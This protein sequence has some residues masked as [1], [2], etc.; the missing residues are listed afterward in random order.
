MLTHSRVSQTL[1][2]GEGGLVVGNTSGRLPLFAK[3]YGGG[4]HMVRHHPMHVQ[5]QRV[6]YAG[7]WQIRHSN[8]LR[9]GLVRIGY[10]Y[11]QNF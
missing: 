10:S 4:D 1:I 7:G 11:L 5:L 8:L 2:G 3:T 6:S 9:Y